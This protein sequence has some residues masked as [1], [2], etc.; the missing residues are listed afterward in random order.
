MLVFFT[1]L[2]LLAFLVRYLALFRRFSIIENFEWFCMES[3]RKNI[4][5]MLVFLKALFLVPH[6]SYYTSM[7]FQMT[8]CV[9]LLSMRMIT[10]LYS[11]CDL[12]SDLWQQLELASELASELLDTIDWNRKW[13]VEFN[14][15]KL[16]L[17]RLT[18]LITLVLLM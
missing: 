16:S 10:I 8:L 1:N 12:A 9:I 6:L 11:K 5:L 13:I 3:L 14:T 18:S 4:Q 15:G 7:T 17:F 2:S